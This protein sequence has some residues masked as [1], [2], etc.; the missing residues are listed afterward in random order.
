MGLDPAKWRE[1]NT[2]FG[3]LVR[4]IVIHLISKLSVWL[5]RFNIY[6][7]CP[8]GIRMVC[9]RILHAVTSADIPW[10]T[11]IEAGRINLVNALTKG[12]TI[13]SF[14]EENTGIS[15]YKFQVVW[16]QLQ[17]ATYL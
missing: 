7:A 2:T 12:Q 10:P 11:M 15:S 14:F 6:T 1:K 4:N 3:G 17:V 8:F 9:Y 16:L 13:R 5:V